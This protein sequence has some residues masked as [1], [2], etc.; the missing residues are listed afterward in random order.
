MAAN[1]QD[2]RLWPITDFVYRF[3]QGV[4]DW[5]GAA[6]SLG[7]PFCYDVAES[8]RARTR[9]A[10]KRVGRMWRMAC[11]VDRSSL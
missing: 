4:T 6:L 8:L 5:P 2:D 9:C 7:R 1:A 11:G 10:Q 3:A